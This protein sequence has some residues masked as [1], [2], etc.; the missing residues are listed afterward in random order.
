ML[1]FMVTVTFI[2]LPSSIA[3][4][5][6]TVSIFPT[7]PLVY[8]SPHH[9]FLFYPPTLSLPS[10]FSQPLAP[11]RSSSQGLID[12]SRF[13]CG[14]GSSLSRVASPAALAALD[15]TVR[16]WWHTRSLNSTVRC[17]AQ[18]YSLRYICNLIHTHTHGE[19]TI[20]ELESRLNKARHQLVSTAHPHRSP[21]RI[22][23]SKCSHRMFIQRRDDFV[24]VFP[25]L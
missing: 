20:G 15:V 1:W 7:F 12:N 24:A 17:Q 4:L 25:L 8:N 5:F 21:S 13:R 10:S 18:R 19:L 6:P 14:A 9:L 2:S 16:S 3:I 22:M 23:P 11:S